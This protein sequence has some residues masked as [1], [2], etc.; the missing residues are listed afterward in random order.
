MEGD[1]NLDSIPA[2]FIGVSDGEKLLRDYVHQEDLHTYL[3]I[4]PDE[5]FIGAYTFF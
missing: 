4:Y 1:P 5:P 2:V 3:A